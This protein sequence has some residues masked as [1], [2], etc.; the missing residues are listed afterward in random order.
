MNLKHLHP[1]LAAVGVLS[2]GLSVA[3]QQPTFRS[4]SRVVP[5]FVTVT[6]VN[7]RLVTDL[8]REDFEILDNSRPQEVTIFG[9]RSA[10][11]QCRRY[12]RQQ[13][14]HDR[15]SQGPVRRAEQFLLRL[16]PQ[17]KAMVG[18]FSDKIEFA[19]G[20]SGDRPSLISSLKELDFGNETRLYDAVLP[21]STSWKGRKAAR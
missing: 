1:G 15:P 10:P 9:Q 11:L 13:H 12:A 8:A 4:G 14:Q 7:T 21:A 3:A 17:D 5:S 2:L 6:D 18:G 16:L 20:F 19:T